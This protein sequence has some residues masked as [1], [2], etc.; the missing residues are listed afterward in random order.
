MKRNIFK[1]RRNA[2]CWDHFYQV[3]T[4]QDG[5]PKVICKNCDHILTH[6]TDK[7]RGTSTM[8]RHYSG[9]TQSQDIRKAIKNGA[10]L[11]SRKASFTP[12]ITFIAA[13]RLPFQLIKYPEFRALL[14]MARL[15]PCFPKIP[16]ATT[17][18]R[19]LQEIVEERQYTLLQKL[20]NSAKLSI[21]LDCW[22]SP[23]RQAFMAITGYFIDQEW[24]YR[25][26]LLGF[27]PL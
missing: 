20:P 12:L 21:A 11:S 17:V 6:P 8:N 16:T 18:R 22:T 10:Y 4:I 3:A 1:G 19:H 13:S 9:P 26:L 5:S 7:R 14:E 24:N 27:E 25:E 15:A 2:E 23:F